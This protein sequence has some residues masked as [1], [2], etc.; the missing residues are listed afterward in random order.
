MACQLDYLCGF[1]SDFERRKALG[2]LPPTLHETYLRVLQRLSRLPTSTQSKI[3]MC[4]QFI[5]FC[6]DRLTT[7]QLREAISTPEV[8]G[9]HLNEDNMVSE[10][11]IAEKCGSLLKKSADDTSFEFAHFSVREFLEHQS[12]VETPGLESYRISQSE[13]HRLLAAQSLRYLQL[14]NFVFDAPDLE[15]LL[16]HIN[17]SFDNNNYSF[18]L[19]AV[20][21]SLGLMARVGSAPILHSLIIS[22]FHPSKT[23][24]LVLFAIGVCNQLVEH[25][26]AKGLISGD[27]QTW[28]RQYAEKLI[29][30]DCQPIH[31]A[32][33]LNLPSVC[34]YLISTGSDCSARSSFGTPF[35][36]SVASILRLVLD[37]FDW[38]SFGALHHHLRDPIQRLLGTGTQ[39]NSTVEIF[40]RTSPVKETPDQ[41]LHSEDTSMLFPVCIIAFTQNDFRVLQRLFSRGMMLKDSAYIAMIR[42]LMDQSVESIE[43]DEQP[44]LEFLQYIGT[45]LEP[46]S[47]WQLEVGRV[48]WNIAVDLGLPFT[49]DPS[50]TDSR[51]SL[52]S[53]A[54]VSRA[55][56]AIANHDTEAL[57]ECLADGRLVLSERHRDPRE[58]H[59]EDDPEHLTLLHF[60]V[61]ENNLQA[62]EVLAQAGCNPNIPSIQLDRRWL[63]IHD[64]PS[65][66]I[67]E[68]LSAHGARATDVETYTGM[69]IW[70]LYGQTSLPDLELFDSLAR[71]Y[72]SET[73]E[74]LLT[75]SKVGHT[76]LQGL[77]L[78]RDSSTLPEDYMDRVM[79]LI[80]ICQ[81]IA[82]FW[83]KHFPLFG[84]AAAFGS[85]KVIRRLID[86]G[87]GIETI[88]PGFETP[89]HRLS[90]NSSSASVQCLKKV[91][92]EAMHIR[93]EGQIPLQTYLEKCL[94]GNNP[95]D[96]SVAQQLWT[97]ES[98]ESIDGRGTSLWEYYCNFNTKNPSIL[99]QTAY[100]MLWAWLLGKSSAMQVYEKGSGK[101]GLMLIISRLISL[102][103]IGDLTSAIPSHTLKHAMDAT[104]C[105][106]T[107]K[108]HSNMLRFLQFAIKKRAYSLVSILIAR[109]VSVHDQVDGYS[110]MQIAFQSP[111]VVSL[112]SDE[113][114]KAILLGM[115]DYSTT[116]HL[117]GYD[118]DGL[119][120]L[121]SLATSDLDGGQGLQWLIETLVHRGADVN[122]FGAFQNNCTPMVY[123][124]EK[125]SVFCA[126]YLLEIGADPGLAGEH[127][128]DAAMQACWWGS[129]NFLRKLLD[130]SK[131]T[132]MLIDWGRKAWLRLRFKDGFVIEMSGANA[133]QCAFAAKS[134]ESLEILQFYVD[135]GLIDDLEYTSDNGW[136]V[137][138][139]AAFHGHAP[140]IEYLVSR[141]CGMMP[142]T[143][144]KCTPL[145]LSVRQGHYEATKILIRLGAKDVADD[146]GMTP[147][148]YASRRKSTSIIQLLGEFPTPET[149]LARGFERDALPR[150][151]SKALINA[152]NK[153]IISDDIKECKR[154]YSL[155]CPLNVSIKDWSPLLLALDK[156]H[157]DIAEWLV[158]NGALTTTRTGHGTNAV[159]ICLNRPELCKLLP[160]LVDQC[161]HDGSGWPLLG[162]SGVWSTIRS[163]NA[164]GLSTLFKLLKDRAGDIRYCVILNFEPCEQLI[165]SYKV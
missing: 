107:T 14:S 146:D 140:I 63:P 95:I 46:A 165:F 75:K 132:G 44:L 121:H 116:D 7:G 20:E 144:Q 109:G 42:E 133:P 143:D 3:Q 70:H 99:N 39:R 24:C 48:I 40:E 87:A 126:T 29:S 74:A 38:T 88:G 92:P 154:L 91:F 101:N 47:G 78:S 32:A 69:N 158:D 164:E 148:M 58:P 112:S 110:S 81:G 102:E 28:H 115:L 161:V 23:S 93:F 106:E 86:V 73:A 104:H 137:M 16:M 108:S 97:A 22:L 57:Q 43:Q 19:W 145:H 118:R 17:M 96:D 111:L 21:N 159:D 25:C 157:L 26:A 33:A 89:L 72:P 83:S 135:N 67:F 122:K 151:R 117:N 45:L 94:H 68:E 27:V 60:A 90:V 138:H 98:L 153:A 12:L 55:F 77:L 128:V 100:A 103:Q 147:T 163:G 62:T 120:I 80:Q 1:S 125:G 56:A 13:C 129:I 124:I 65:I 150:N 149:S 85:E 64:C 76:P 41:F 37:G 105:W 142:E 82:N 139:F 79:A 113:D 84:A 130:H 123:H 152:L 59:D 49:R 51:I 18:Y 34:D 136:T 66:D 119:T 127:C 114:G 35:E 61:S 134:A 15:S 156:G 2:Q 31:L 6:P 54:L 53:D 141:G 8:L 162:S 9:S 52:S 10:D 36:L 160:K 131:Q 50:V 11:E 71:R 30:A 155:N 5:A 4:F